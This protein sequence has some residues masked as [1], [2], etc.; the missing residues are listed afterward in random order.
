MKKV[1]YISGYN[2]LTKEKIY[3]VIEIK[4]RWKFEMI[5][6]KNDFNNEQWYATQ[7]VFWGKSLFIDA[8]PEYTR[9]ETITEILS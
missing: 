8:A 9:N 6:I 1:K 3:D 5:L 7:E 4:Y 2:G